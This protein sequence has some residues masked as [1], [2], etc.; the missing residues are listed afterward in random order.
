MKVLLKKRRF[1]LLTVGLLFC[2]G[3]CER[4]GS[5]RPTSE[6]AKEVLKLRGYNFDERS[7]LRAAAEA[8]LIAV[9]GFLSA[10][11]NPNAKDENGDTALT[12]AASRGD[13]NIVNA[14]VEGGADV[15]A[16]GRNTWT[17]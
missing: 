13:L 15:N 2:L 10:G 1:K 6:A 4:A 16:K 3:A 8:D 5:D 9:N 12:S 11:I 7:F 14:L 17:A